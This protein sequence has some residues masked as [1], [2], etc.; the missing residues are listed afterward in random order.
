[1]LCLGLKI[2]DNIIY[3]YWIP[4]MK[5]DRF[6]TIICIFLLLGWVGVS[7]AGSSI[8]CGNNLISVGDL[9]I[10]VLDRCGEPILKEKIELNSSRRRRSNDNYRYVEQWTYEFHYG[11]YDVLTFKGGKLIKIESMIPK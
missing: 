8:R 2:V 5:S 9:K 6:T 3:F 10:K 1:M 4:Y 11:Y 7:F